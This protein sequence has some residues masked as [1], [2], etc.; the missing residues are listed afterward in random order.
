MHTT[1]RPPT[2][3][4]T[5]NFPPLGGG[6]SRYYGELAAA[7]GPSMRVDS[8]F[9]GELAMPSGNGVV[10]RLAQLRHVWEH[11]YEGCFPLA[12]HPHL[13]LPFAL[14]RQPFGLIIHGGEWARLGSLGPKVVDGLAARADLVIA[15]SHAT[16][17]RWLGQAG[18]RTRLEIV[19]PGVP[20]SWVRAGREAAGRRE[21]SAPFR[22]L[23]VTRLVTRKRVPALVRAVLEIAQQMPGELIFDV[24][25]GG[26]EFEAVRA[27]ADGHEDLVRV[28]G[29]VTDDDLRRLYAQ[30]HGFALCPT[31]LTEDEGFEGY[32]IVYLEAAAFGLPILASDAG[33]ITEALTPNG[34][35]VVQPDDWGAVQN[36]IRSWVADPGRASS[37]G[38]RNLAWAQENIWESRAERLAQALAKA[39]R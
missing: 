9:S 30:A 17:R 33:G 21:H 34:S 22:L 10:P 14:R 35:E 25:G 4:I 2:A 12:G 16:A 26:P 20:S 6:V 39:S 18:R 37:M 32:G 27:E 15:N 1:T 7:Y 28:H 31:E 13:A 11:E 19:H 38:L 23:T 29:E 3:L 36:V 24:V 8:P 5:Y